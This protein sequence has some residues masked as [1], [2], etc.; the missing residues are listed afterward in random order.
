MLGHLELELQADVYWEAN[1]CPLQQ[2]QP[3]LMLTHLFSHNS[4]KLNSRFLWVTSLDLCSGNHKARVLVD[5]VPLRNHRSFKLM[6]LSAEVS[7]SGQRASPLVFGL[8]STSLLPSLHWDSQ[9]SCSNLPGGSITDEQ[10][11]HG[12]FLSCYWSDPCNS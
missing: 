2:Q 10:H 3:V 7:S 5:C 12:P 4:L 1:S 9:L 11:T 6:Q 8:I